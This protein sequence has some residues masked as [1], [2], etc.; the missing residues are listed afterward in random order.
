MKDH[1]LATQDIKATDKQNDAT[2]IMEN[3]IKFLITKAE[4]KEGKV[5][6]IGMPPINFDNFLDFQEYFE[7]MNALNESEIILNMKKKADI[8]EVETKSNPSS[9]TS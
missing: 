8:Q 1:R 2:A 7:L 9:S 5:I 3:L 4:D 6:E